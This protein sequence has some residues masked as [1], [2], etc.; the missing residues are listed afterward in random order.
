MG[1]GRMG[2]GCLV[3]VLAAWILIDYFMCF[4]AGVDV[5]F[6]RALHIEF[7]IG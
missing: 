1:F 2:P 4:E 7:F 5:L 6:F 3:L